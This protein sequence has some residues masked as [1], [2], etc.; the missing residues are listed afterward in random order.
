M[1]PSP[2]IYLHVK[3]VLYS[4]TF[5]GPVY[6]WTANPGINLSAALELFRC[7]ASPDRNAV[8]LIPDIRLS[9]S[10]SSR[11]QFVAEL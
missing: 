6:S 1:T 7:I 3:R 9:S 5:S 4:V 10:L 8:G 2:H 11:L